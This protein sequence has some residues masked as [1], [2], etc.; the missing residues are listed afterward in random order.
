[1]NKEIMK[2]TQTMEYNS[3]SS[4]KAI[5]GVELEIDMIFP[6]QYREFMLETNGAEGNIGQNSYLAIWSIEEI[7]PLNIDG[8]VEEFTPG[9]VQFASDGGG[10]AYA[11]DKRDKEI[12]IVA[13]PDDSIHIEDA[14]FLGKTFQDFL[15]YLHDA[16]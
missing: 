4:K 15:Q 6:T 3:F 1:M 10:M 11:F 16:D 12:S 5:K 2:L 8:K 7:V 13:I 14:E 9:L